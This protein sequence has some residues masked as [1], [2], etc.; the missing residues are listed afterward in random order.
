MPKKIEW[1]LTI[2]NDE[3][4]TKEQRG[5]LLNCIADEIELY[6]SESGEYKSETFTEDDEPI[7]IGHQPY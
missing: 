7:V 1:Y 4:L 3:D 2:Y 6:K 5:E